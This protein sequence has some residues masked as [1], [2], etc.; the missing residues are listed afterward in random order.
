MQKKSGILLVNLGTPD[1]PTAAAVRRYLREFLSDP[2]VVNIPRAIW[3]PILYGIILPLRPRRVAKL[4][5]SIWGATDSPLR[6]IGGQLQ[7]GIAA[8]IE[9]VCGESMSVVMGMTYGKPSIEEAIQLLQQHGVERIVVLPLFPQYSSAATGA[10]CDV[11][12]KALQRLV[13]VPEITLINS[14]HNE[15]AY[16][17]A[18]AQ[19]VRTHWQQQGK[20]KRLLMSFHGIPKQQSD[21]GDP[22]TRQCAETACY[23]A[24]ELGLASHEWQYTF[25]S[26]F[27]KA[28]W[29]KPYTDKT[30]ACWADEGVDSV[31]VICPGFAVD[32]LETLEEMAIQNKELFLE[33]G[34]KEYRF[35]PALNASGGHIH[36]LTELIVDR[37][38]GHTDQSLSQPEKILARA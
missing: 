15:P 24:A 8:E 37:L 23:L 38:N 28:E 30:L 22:Y 29:V 9:Q 26:R 36:C 21:A 6:E 34:G 19:T 16:I 14:Y 31:D 25:Q 27:G 32:C 20:A 17:E 18:L 33:H 13:H 11:L 3:L 35:I 4:Y 12:A 5:Q 2:R 7:Q 10:A 1:A